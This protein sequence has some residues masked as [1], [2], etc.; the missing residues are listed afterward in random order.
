[1]GENALYNYFMQIYNFR[2]QRDGE[3]VSISPEFA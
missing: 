3:D 2:K 1:M